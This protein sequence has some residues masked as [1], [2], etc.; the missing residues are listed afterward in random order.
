MK[1]S[2]AR[3]E[4]WNFWRQI[5]QAP[6]NRKAILLLPNQMNVRVRSEVGYVWYDGSIWCGEGCLLLGG[7]SAPKIS[8]GHGFGAVAMLL[9]LQCEGCLQGSEMS[10]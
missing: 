10:K 2:A 3:K 6:G 1:A 5:Y 8:N 9:A 7:R 4:A